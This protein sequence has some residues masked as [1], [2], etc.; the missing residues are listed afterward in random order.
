VAILKKRPS[1]NLNVKRGYADLFSVFGERKSG[2]TIR[3]NFSGSAFSSSRLER[4]SSVR[5]FSLTGFFGF[6]FWRGTPEA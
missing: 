4:S 1:T 2:L 6:D 3:L 5:V